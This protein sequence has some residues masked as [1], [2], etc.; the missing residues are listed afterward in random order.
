MREL[1]PTVSSTSNGALSISRRHH[2]A[3]YELRLYEG[4]ARF[5]V[6]Y[7]TVRGNTS[8]TAGVQK[9]DTDFDQ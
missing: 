2:P 6:I 3:N 9:N 1:R 5:D 4:Q 7:G 8:A